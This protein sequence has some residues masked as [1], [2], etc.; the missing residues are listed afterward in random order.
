MN[1]ESF[2]ENKIRLENERALIEPLQEKHFEFLL[3]VALHT[4]LWE[5]SSSKINTETDFKKYF[6]AALSERAAG[7]SYPFAIYDKLNKQYAGS[8]RF[9]AISLPNKRMEIGF[10][11]YH[12]SLQR[13]GINKA[14]KYLLLQYGF[15][16]LDLNRI[17]LKTNVLNVKSQGAMLK[18]GALKEGVFR[19]HI[20]NDDGTIRDTMYFSFI[21]E[22]WP[23][24][25][26]TF[27]TE[28]AAV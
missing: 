21:K 18:I 8:T 16:I 22:E 20:L 3:P 10:T 14:C 24:I 12:P 25:K 2:F 28:F 6:N 17:E 1:P 5:F 4:E 11:W 13:T 26:T 7:S 23:K 19:R 27:F 15:E 9:T